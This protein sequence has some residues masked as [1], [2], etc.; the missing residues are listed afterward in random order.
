MAKGAR[1][2]VEPPSITLIT[3]LPNTPILADVGVPASVPVVESKLAHAGFPEIAKVSVEWPGPEA[4][5]VKLYGWP[6]TSVV[7]GVPEMVS[8]ELPK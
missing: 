7:A 1:D 2:D 6:V 4:E 5:G 8:F 3:M